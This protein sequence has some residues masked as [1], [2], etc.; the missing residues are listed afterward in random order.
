MK[1][2]RSFVALEIDSAAAGALERAG[3]AAAGLDR[4]V[5]GLKKDTLHMTVAFLGEIEPELTGAIHAASRAAFE[6][7]QAETLSS[8]GA[9]FFPSARRPATLCL[10]LEKSAVLA[11]SVRRLHV[12]LAATGFRP[13]R[14]VFRP[15]VT[16]ARLRTGFDETQLGELVKTVAPHLPAAVTVTGVGQYESVLE[17]SGAHYVPLWRIGFWNR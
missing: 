15:H 12:N 14:R 2:I 9:V 10:E 11:E 13:D 3:R 6:T 1:T 7:A 8:V 16:F 17:K 5:R 4:R